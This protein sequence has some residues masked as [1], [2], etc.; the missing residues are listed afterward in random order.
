MDTA[1]FSCWPNIVKYRHTHTHTHTHTHKLHMNHTGHSQRWDRNHSVVDKAG[2]HS[3]IEGVSVLC[4]GRAL[5]C[6]GMTNTFCKIL[7]TNKK[8][9]AMSSIFFN[10]MLKDPLWVKSNYMI[11][12]L[13]TYKYCK[14]MTSPQEISCLCLSLPPSIFLSLHC[15]GSKQSKSSGSSTNCLVVGTNW[16]TF[17]AFLKV[18]TGMT[19]HH[20]WSFNDKCSI[21]GVALSGN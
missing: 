4:I 13:Y 20:Y 11:F 2:F 21:S 12:T 9:F 6:N 5:L 16:K 17:Q 19:H 3:Q 8:G 14:I 7:E 10:I 15:L 1:H 18:L